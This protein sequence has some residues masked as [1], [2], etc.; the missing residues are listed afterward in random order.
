MAYSGTIVICDH[1]REEV[2][3]VARF[4]PNCSTAPKRKEMDDE[5]RKHFKEHG[6]E[7]HCEFCERQAMQRE[8]AKEQR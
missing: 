4:C 6:L 8:L 1:C 5:N 2:K 3:G 7:Y